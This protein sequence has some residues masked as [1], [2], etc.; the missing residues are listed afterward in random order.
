MLCD[1]GFAV[2][3][4]RESRRLSKSELARKVRTS[5]TYVYRVEAREIVPTIDVIARFAGAFGI[6]PRVLIVLAS[7]KASQDAR[8]PVLPALER[9]QRLPHR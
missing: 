3:I 8:L 5:R 2:R 6:S 1:I 7:S 4:L 9:D